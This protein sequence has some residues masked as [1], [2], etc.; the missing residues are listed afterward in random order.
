MRILPEDAEVYISSE[1][2]QS[3]CEDV[4]NVRMLK[5]NFVKRYEREKMWFILFRR[6]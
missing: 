4:Y 6:I 1:E 3:E 5:I 2:G